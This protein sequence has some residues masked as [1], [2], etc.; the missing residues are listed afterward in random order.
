MGKMRYP[1]QLA[2]VLILATAA[3]A[4]MDA[5]PST[6]QWIEDKANQMAKPPQLG[7]VQ[8]PGPQGYQNTNSKPFMKKEGPNK[9]QWNQK[10][11][12]MKKHHN[13]WKNKHWKNDKWQ[14]KGA[15]SKEDIMKKKQDWMK[16]KGWSKEDIMK[17][18]QQWMQ[19]KGDWKKGDWMKKKEDWMKKKGWSKEDIMKKKQEWMQ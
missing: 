11:E 6:D 19:K 13:K 17:K 4:Q 15:W 7:G 3:M 14:K 2:I 5:M 10:R 18:K 9:D 16:K 12:W 1:K 8:M